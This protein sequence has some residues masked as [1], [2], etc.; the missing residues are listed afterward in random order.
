MLSKM[1]FLLGCMYQ[2]QAAELGVNPNHVY[3]IWRNINYAAEELFIEIHG[4]SL[5]HASNVRQRNFMGKTC[6]DVME[7][8][9]KLNQDLALVIDI[10]V[11]QPE[12][13]WVTEYE[14]LENF[15]TNVS[16]DLKPKTASDV[17]VLSSRILNT[18]VNRY[19]EV[20][21]G[22]KSIRHF[23]PENTTISEGKTPDDVY[24]ELDLLATKLKYVLAHPISLAGAE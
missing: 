6:D 9:H 23:Y 5:D 3:D 1:M 8:A 10:K 15:E 18:I 21:D 4:V 24:A 14:N 22:E 16:G 13:V 17:Y 19:V 20:T 7:K 2:T 12:P 11:I